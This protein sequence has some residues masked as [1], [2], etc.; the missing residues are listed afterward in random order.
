MWEFQQSVTKNS[1][2]K[3]QVWATWSEVSN[4][5]KWDDD[6]E[7]SE[8]VFGDNSTLL[9]RPKSGP[10]ITA[11]MTCVPDESFTVNSNLPLWTRLEFVHI[12]KNSS[13]GLEITHGIKISGPLTFL[14]RYIIGRSVEANLPIAME[15]L[16]QIAK[17]K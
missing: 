4:W 1:L 14:F 12:I 6:I 3:E 16:V 15:K 8:G 11:T 10:S 2:S 9:I 17:S 7:S 13:A 5:N